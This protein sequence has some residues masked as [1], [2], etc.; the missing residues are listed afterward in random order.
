LLVFPPIPPNTYP[1][2]PS[3]KG[4]IAINSRFFNIFLIDYQCFKNFF[5]IFCNLFS[6]PLVK[7]ITNNIKLKNMKNADNNTNKVLVVT[8]NPTF[9][10]DVKNQLAHCDVLST[11]SAAVAFGLVLP[12]QVQV[13]VVDQYLTD[14]TGANFLASL[15]LA[16]PQV[17]SVFVV[18]NETDMN[19]VELVNMS[20]PFHVQTLPVNMEELT[21]TVNA[22]VEMYQNEFEKEQTFEELTLKNQQ[23]EFL[24]RQS[25]L[26]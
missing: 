24:L 2:A 22:A 10:A 11:D 15:A 6:T 19:W 25:L 21:S 7:D 1:T 3:F 18:Q 23:Y 4:L 5:N 16:F 14:G 13:V 17:K 12:E 20:R 26:S 8:A 9:A